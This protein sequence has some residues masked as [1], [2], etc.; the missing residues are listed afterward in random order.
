MGEGFCF[1]GGFC[2]EGFPAEV[3]KEEAADEAEPELAG[4]EKIGNDG[5]AKGGDNGVKGICKGGTET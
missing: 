3:E 5:E 2:D 4:E 1:G